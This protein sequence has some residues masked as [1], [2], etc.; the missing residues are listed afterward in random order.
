MEII[1]EWLLSHRIYYSAETLRNVLIVSGIFIL[2]L[3]KYGV[4]KNNK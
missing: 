4:F 2:T 1:N 3:W